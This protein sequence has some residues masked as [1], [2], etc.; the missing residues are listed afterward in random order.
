M[1]E[2][3][4]Y[5]FS[6]QASIYIFIMLCFSWLQ[7]LWGNLTYFLLFSIHCT[8]IDFTFRSRQ[9]PEHVCRTGFSDRVLVFLSN[10]DGD[11]HRKSCRLYDLKTV[12][13][14][15]QLPEW[16]GLSELHQILLP[17]RGRQWGVLFSNE[18]HWREL[19]WAME[20]YELREKQRKKWPFGL[21]LSARWPLFQNVRTYQWNWVSEVVQ[22]RRGSSPQWGVCVYPWNTND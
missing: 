16:I 22:G 12:N 5:Q 15:N 6:F 7:L 9:N 10:H 17:R 4:I 14:R 3:I 2:Y 13:H 8:I 21:G 20:E 19:L 1:Y 11:L 18:R